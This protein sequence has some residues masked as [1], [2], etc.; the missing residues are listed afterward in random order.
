MIR[1]NLFIPRLFPSVLDHQTRVD[2]VGG[3]F[4]LFF[5]CCCTAEGAAGVRLIPS[6]HGSEVNVNV[7]E[8][9]NVNVS[10]F[11]NVNVINI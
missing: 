10:E 5:F 9:V 6:L 1:P 3:F 11:M 7:S 8:F 2:T 4:F